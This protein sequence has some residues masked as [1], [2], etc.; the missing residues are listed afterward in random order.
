MAVRGVDKGTV[1][2]SYDSIVEPHASF[3]LPSSWGENADDSVPVIDGD[4]MKSI[5]AENVNRG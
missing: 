4:S 3:E 1:R 2:L 5:F